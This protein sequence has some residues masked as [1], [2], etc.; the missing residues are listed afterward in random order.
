MPEPY[1]QA[2]VDAMRERWADHLPKPAVV[3]A[4]ATGHIPGTVCDVQ[5]TA[6]HPHGYCVTH[7]GPVRNTDPGCEGGQAL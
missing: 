6:D 2:A 3:G 7:A 1:S 5:R 4:D